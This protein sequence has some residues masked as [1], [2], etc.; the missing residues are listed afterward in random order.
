MAN[1]KISAVDAL[2]TLADGD[3]FVVVDVSETG[4]AGNKK[5]TKA[6]LMVDVGAYVDDA[7]LTLTNK[8]ISR[9]SNTMSA[10]ADLI[11]GT[12]GDYTDIQSALDAATGGKTIY[13]EDGTYTITSTL[14]V[15]YDKTRLIV[16]D[17]ATIQCN[18]ASVSPLIDWD[19]GVDSCTVIGG[20]WHNSGTDGNGVCFDISDSSNNY[21][22]PTKIDDFALGIKLVDTA[23][24]TFY[25][26]VERANIFDCTT[27]VHLA[28]QANN[29]TFNALRIRPLAA[30]AGYG[31]LIDDSRGNVF[32]GCNVEPATGTGITGVYLK[33]VN[34]STR[35][36]DNTFLNCWLENSQVTVLID[37]DSFNNNF[38]GCTFVGDDGGADITD[39]STFGNNRFF[40]SNPDSSS[41]QMNVVGTITD[42][43]R[44]EI[45]AFGETAAAVNEVTITNNSTGAL[46]KIAASGETNIG[47]LL[48]GK[49]TGK[50][51][52][53]D[54]ADNTKLVRFETVNATTGTRTQ[55]DFA[56]TANRT[57]T[58]P[59]LT[60][61][62]VG[63]DASGVTDNSIVRFDGTTGKLI[64]TSSVTINDGG[65]IQAAALIS[66]TSVYAGDGTVSAPGFMFAADQNVGLYRVGADV[67]GVTVGGTD[68]MRFNTATTAVNY[69]NITPSAAGSPLTIASAGT[70]T[71]VGITI[72]TKGAG[73]VT[74]AGAAA[75]TGTTT[76]AT[77]LTGVLRAD[78][79]VVS[80][81]TDVTDLVTAATT[82]AAGKVE[83]AIASE[84]NTGTDTGRAIGVD[85]FAG[86]N[87]G[88]RIIQVKVFDDATAAT[89]GDGKVIFMIPVEFNG[90]N[91]VDVEAYVS[92]VSSSGALTIMVRNVTQAADM[93]STAITIDVSE[94][95]SLT[96]AVAPV[97]DAANDDVATGDLIAIDVDG[98]GTSAEGLGVV[99]SFQLP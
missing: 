33:S 12:N 44:N 91:L 30:G 53:G 77:S 58:F 94:N 13:V 46:P 19:T 11:V 3:S 65:T 48:T 68:V 55:L 21:I 17:G 8:T 97:I 76:L 86:S 37:T 75:I 5:I 62:L 4:D 71:D 6:N 79:G 28:A 57:I 23:D 72:D 98:A 64:Q 56:Q 25:N 89:T 20:Y 22:A 83:L 39:N 99:L 27:G 15:K 80:V 90:M 7:T 70:D 59:D 81:D 49:G 88:K 60:T 92:G 16:S 82:S 45:L 43:N 50:V 38:F 63:S 95:S 35:A 9:A 52:I 74:I 69:F 31:I 24:L 85:E 1:R 10:A 41:A 87:F 96:A 29:N 67:M 73:A 93:L 32:T 36:K 2:T 40:A 51:T 34:S 26:Y 18:G 66:S 14:L 47:L 84:I 78:S 42:R 54:A 61:T